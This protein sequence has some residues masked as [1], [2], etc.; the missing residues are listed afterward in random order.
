LAW[1]PHIEP[2]TGSIGMLFLVSDWMI[3][4][5]SARLNL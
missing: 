3:V 5:G 4:K 1:L 2:I